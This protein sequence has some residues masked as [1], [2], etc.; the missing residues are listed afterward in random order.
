MWLGRGRLPFC[1]APC[2]RVAKGGEVKAIGVPIGNGAYTADNTI[3]MVRAGGMKQLARMLPLMPDKTVG[4]PDLQLHGA[5]DLVRGAGSGLRAVPA[6]V[7]EGTLTPYG[8]LN[9][10]SSFQGQ[11]KN[12]R[13]SRTDAR[14]AS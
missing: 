7:S 12:R 14:R 13:S 10:C 3:E 11:R 8:C 5:A 6:R 2:V 9:A 1:G 4:Q